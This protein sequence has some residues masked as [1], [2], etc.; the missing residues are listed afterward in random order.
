MLQMD[1]EAATAIMRDLDNLSAAAI[2]RRL[3]GDEDAARQIGKYFP[4]VQDK[5]LNLIQLNRAGN[6]Q[7]ALVAATI[8]QKTKQLSVVRFP[9]AIDL[10]KNLRHLK[11]LAAPR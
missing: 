6:A 8:A 11:Y 1:T 9:I 7:S 2:L 10:R 5:L 3:S 4:E